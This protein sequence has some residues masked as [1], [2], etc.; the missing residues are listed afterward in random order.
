VKV[1]VFKWL[2]VWRLVRGLS[3]LMVQIG[4]ASK[5]NGRGPGTGNN[6]LSSRLEELLS[7]RSCMQENKFGL[8]HYRIVG[9]DDSLDT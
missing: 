3:M 4:R 5:A 9:A 6:F 1:K 8:S 2:G 7:S